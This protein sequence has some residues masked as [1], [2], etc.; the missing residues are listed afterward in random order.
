MFNATETTTIFAIVLIALG[1]GVWGYNRAKSYGKLG[2]LTWLQSVVLIVPWLV[3]FACY[4]LGIYLNLVG[5]LFLIVSSSIAYII[6]GNRLRAESQETI[7]RQRLANAIEKDK[8]ANNLDRT[9]SQAE[10][11]EVATQA[12]DP[13]PKK[14]PNQLGPEIHPIEEEDLKIIKGIFGI[15]TFFATETIS[16]QEGAIFKGNLR[17]EAENSHARLSQKLKDALGEKYRLFLVE[18]PEGKPVVIVLPASNDPQPS[19]LALK[20][21]ALVL[22]LATIVTSLEAAGLLLGFDLFVSPDRYLEALPI[23]LGLWTIL[24]GHE[25]GHWL[26]AR[27]Y[28]LRLSLPYLIPS[29]QIG[30][31]GS[32]TR[33]ES[34][35]PNRTTLFDVAIA[36]PALGAIVSLV[37]LI[38]GFII[39]HPGST[40]QIETQFFQASILVGSI[41]RILLGSQMSQALIS[42]SPLVIVGWLGLVISALNLMPAG[43][44]DGGR[45]VQAIYGR[46]TARRTTIATLIVLAIVSVTN[47]NNAIPLYWGI[48][49]L[50]LQRDLERPSLNEL[51]EPDDTRAVWGLLA[52]LLMLATLIPLSPTLAARL[53]IGV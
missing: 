29:L 6:I 23:G 17:G 26:A 20:N 31:F 32:I 15:D 37:M 50:F 13:L 48:L 25:I 46:K 44:L 28:K 3:F 30:A 53:G 14:D 49:I 47:P 22:F 40:F 51:T 11:P 36:G 39:S 4:A 43:Q 33:F 8:D 10:I 2:T 16:Y 34:L 45:I 42:I 24:I 9:D 12:K 38:F 27:K 7:L 5:V 19:T 41:A 35:I 52:L 1:I 18:S 21:L